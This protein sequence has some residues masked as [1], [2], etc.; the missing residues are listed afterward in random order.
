MLMPDDVKKYFY[1]QPV[2]MRKSINTLC[3]FDIRNIDAESS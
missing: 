3:M 2:D 1:T